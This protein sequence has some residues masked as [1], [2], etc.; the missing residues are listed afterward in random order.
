[1]WHTPMYIRRSGIVLQAPDMNYTGEKPWDPVTV[2]AFPA[3]GQSATRTLYED[4]GRSNDY[5]Q[6]H[7]RGSAASLSSSGDGVRLIIGKGEGEFKGAVKQRA[8]NVRIHLLPGQSVKAA[9]LV[10]KA[11]EFRLIHAGKDHVKMPFSGMGST[12]GR[13]AGPVVEVA[14]P[15]LSATREYRLELTLG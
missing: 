2:D 14:L 4:D 1:M 12:P 13:Q 10:G 7:F 11:L 5:V 8:W 3:S 15:K 6:G 9:S